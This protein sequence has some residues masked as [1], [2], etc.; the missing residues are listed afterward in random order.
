MGV[1]ENIFFFL[2]ALVKGAYFVWLSIAVL[3]GLAVFIGRVALRIATFNKREKELTQQ[4]EDLARKRKEIEWQEQRI[5]PDLDALDMLVKEQT[6]GFPWLAHAYAEYLALQ[7]L[8]R[9]DALVKKSPPARKAAEEIRQMAQRRRDAEKLWRIFRYQLEYYEALFP[10]LIDFK[11]EDIDALIR[12]VLEK[13][14]GVA[15]SDG[16]D[17]AKQWLTAQEYATFTTAEKYQRALDRY[18]QGRKTAWQVG[19]DYERYIGYLYEQEGWRVRYHGIVEGLADLGR[20]LIA[21]RNNEVHIIQ[22]KHWSLQHKRIVHERHI[23]QLYGTVAAYKIDN[24]TSVVLPVFFTSTIL[25]DRAKQ[26]ADVL[27]VRYYENVPLQPYP[28]IKCNI[29]RRDGTKIYHLPFDQQYDRTIIEE[30]KTELYVSTVQEA[31]DLGFRR[32]FR[33]RGQDQQ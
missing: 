2:G 9:A 24:R 25:S 1:F 16:D 17:P 32:A 11:E 19:R 15:D 6:Q 5:G 26:F 18:W 27:Q 4:R 22:C 21:Q 33:W 10:W 13:K 29:S 28:C 3:V 14:E 12:Q 23:F 8:R 30:E 20:D 31:E 7:D